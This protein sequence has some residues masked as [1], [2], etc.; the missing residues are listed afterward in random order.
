VTSS[1]L[2]IIAGKESAGGTQLF[3]PT[4][5]SS[6]NAQ[7]WYGIT[8]G[9]W[10]QYAPQAGVSL[11]QYPDP[12]SAPQSV[13]AAVANQIPLSRWAPST[14]AAVTS[15][16]P[17]VDVSQTVGTLGSSGAIPPATDPL[18]GEPLGPGGSTTG[19]GIVGNQ[20]AQPGSIASNLTSGLINVTWEYVSRALLIFF[21]FALIMIG[22][23]AL[24]FQSKTIKT[25]AAALAA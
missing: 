5:T 24:L 1:I 15:A 21:G 7:G 13:Q 8:S 11:G 6:G 23:V 12:N 16:Y 4:P 18:S 10:Q 2:D 9:T 19:S 3:N 17:G 20:N 22:L 25:T 14:V